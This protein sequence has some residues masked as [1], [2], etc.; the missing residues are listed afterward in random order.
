MPKPLF[1]PVRDGSKELF[2]LVNGFLEESQEAF[3]VHRR[4]HNPGVQWRRPGL[5]IVL[6][7]VQNELEGVVSDLEMVGVLPVRLTVM[8]HVLPFT[9][10][11]DLSMQRF[12]L[13]SKYP[14][15]NRVKRKHSVNRHL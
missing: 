6:A 11:D 3:R 1:V 2:I 5:R 13:L 7:K 8:L 14:C 15:S 10:Y 9:V 4:S 12:D